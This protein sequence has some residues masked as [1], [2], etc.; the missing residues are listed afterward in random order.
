MIRALCL[1]FVLL[2]ALAV[3]AAAHNVTVGADLRIAQTIAGHEVTVVVEGTERVP[4]PLRVGVV[5]FQPVTGL[6]VALE[7]RSVADGRRVTGEVRAEGSGGFTEL[8]VERTGPYELT[9]RAGGETAV[10]PFR[11]LVQRGSA[12]EALIY[13]GLFVAG[14]LA[15]GALLTGALSRRTPA[16]VLAGG[17]GAAL[18]FAVVMVVVEP[19]LPASPPDGAAPV[20]ATPIAGRPFVQARV[21]TVPERPT[22]GAGFTLRIDLTDGSTGTPVDDLALHHEALAHVVVTSRDGGFFRHLHPPRRAPGR[23]SA[24]LA[25]VPA[26]S[27]LVHVELEREDSGG[28]LVSG[29]FTVDGE[30]S[31]Q[32]SVPPLVRTGVTVRPAAPVAGRPATIG[33]AI[34]GAGRPWLGMT[35]HLIVRDGDGTYFGHVHA[36]G[37]SGR[38][39]RFTFNFPRP[40]RYLAWAQYA[41]DTGITTVPFTV[42]VAGGGGAR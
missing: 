17:V 12:T 16:M 21:A 5:A 38:E 2:V 19:M 28:Q 10:L 26:G 22:A 27:Y 25:G 24:V 23:L 8:R 29:G 3:P 42:D 37:R 36:M 11:V 4:G 33:V 18:T 39:A 9:L 41:T 35:G 7:L 32:A 34:N 1:A 13:A 40:G 31:K 30:P 15:V 14:T 6:S 20:P